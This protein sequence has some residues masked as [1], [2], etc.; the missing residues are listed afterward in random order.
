MKPVRTFLRNEEIKFFLRLHS[1][2]EGIIH[3]PRP[4]RPEMLEDGRKVPSG[5][6]TYYGSKETIL[7]SHPP[8]NRIIPE[9]RMKAFER[10]E[11][12]I[13][14][15]PGHYKEWLDAIRG[16]KPAS[17]NFTDYSGPLTELVLLGNLA[18]R[19]GKKIN[20][21]AKNM[22]AKGCPEA[23]QYIRRAYREGWGFWKG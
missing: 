5:G 14:R 23:D 4:P 13:E 18:I 1:L 7:A 6:I 10:P 21:D 2:W 11:P 8:S 9:A 3:L 22:K 16:G 19:T 12:F 17:S 15:S 20:W